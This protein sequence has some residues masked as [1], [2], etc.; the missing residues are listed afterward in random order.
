[1]QRGRQ[2]RIA[3]DL[4]EGEMGQGNWSSDSD[5]GLKKGCSGGDLGGG[6]DS[7]QHH[8]D[9]GMGGNTVTA[10]EGGLIETRE[11]EGETCH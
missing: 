5:R 7:T 3:H 1:M 8:V 4:A 10:E 11:E 6:F 2:R 9:E